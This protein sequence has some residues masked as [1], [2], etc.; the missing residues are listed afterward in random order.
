VLLPHLD[1]AST[2]WCVV[3]LT[4]SATSKEL[5]CI[6]IY[7]W[8]KQKRV[9][10]ESL[11]QK[12]LK[13]F[14]SI[15][16][17]R[18]VFVFQESLS[19]LLSLHVIA[20][21]HT[22]P[23]EHVI[24]A[25][26]NLQNL[27]FQHTQ[28]RHFLNDLTESMVSCQESDIQTRL[29]EDDVLSTQH[30]SAVRGFHLH[31]DPVLC[32]PTQTSKTKRPS[33]VAHS[34]PT[35]VESQSSPNPKRTKTTPV[36]NTPVTSTVEV[37][38]TTPL[39]KRR[40]PSNEILTNITLPA[41]P[42][43]ANTLHEKIG[44]AAS[45]NEDE[46]ADVSLSRALTKI[47]AGKR[48]RTVDDST[49]AE[50]ACSH[51]KIQR[52]LHAD[53]A[54]KRAHDEAHRGI[55]DPARVLELQKTSRSST[56]ADS[57]LFGARAVQHLRKELERT[58]ALE[59]IAT[60]SSASSNRAQSHTRN[61]NFLSQEEHLPSLDS[62]P[63]MV[64]QIVAEH[65]TLQPVQHIDEILG[66]T[67]GE[68][69]FPCNGNVGMHNLGNTCYANSLLQALSALTLVQNWTRQHVTLHS[70]ANNFCLLCTLGHDL[71]QLVSSPHPLITTPTTVLM[72]QHWCPTFV[73]GRQQDV[74]EFWTILRDRCN[75][76]DLESY[77]LVD[78][79]LPLHSPV[80]YTTPF[81]N[82]FGIKGYDMTTC[83]PCG[84]TVTSHWY[85][86]ELQVEI[87]LG[88]QQTLQA[89]IVF[90]YST[91]LDDSNDKCEHRCRRRMCRCKQAFVTS[92]P[93]ILTVQLKR[94]IPVGLPGVYIKEHRPVTLPDLL[95]NLPGDATVKYTLRAAVVH[96]G[97]AGGGHYINL[98]KSRYS[99]SWIL[100]SDTSVTN[101]GE[102]MPEKLKQAFL[103]FYER[104]EA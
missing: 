10:L 17:R 86:S 52:D 91:E 82:I 1:K 18:R 19:Y 67:E 75:A 42:C 34:A 102:S 72:L 66:Y 53:A 29:T 27:P 35:N 15:N 41:P 36:G 69:C 80:R 85:R 55:H 98:T 90:F 56:Q 30:A 58:R 33:S 59:K 95:Q 14:P 22:R 9:C 77:T 7:H 71:T 45:T 3:A 20:Q 37:D 97:Q 8:H 92:W 48:A 4:R 103:I 49:I 51:E 46:N 6:D 12:L 26:E 5:T 57:E 16:I 25:S 79:E 32:T 93:P 2:S 47:N 87:P 81:W 21:L 88:R 38:F 40:K 54:A 50:S 64:P 23:H 100:S 61:T 44:E 28:L 62:L 31:A 94:W 60:T 84:Q 65:L 101:T 99:D 43:E 74:S 104:T 83:T 24:L 63:L 89:C 78:P 39:L 13:L 96:E 73:L 70:H 68:L 11:E 76:V